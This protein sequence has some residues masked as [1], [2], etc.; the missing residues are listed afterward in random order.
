MQN[1]DHHVFQEK[2]KN[3]RVLQQSFHPTIYFAPEIIDQ[4]D[5]KPS[6]PNNNVK[7]M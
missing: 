5:A 2:Y 4:L 1:I 7:D 3:Y 6:P